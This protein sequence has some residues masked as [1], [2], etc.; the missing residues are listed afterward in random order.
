[1]TVLQFE[2]CQK[3]WSPFKF[4]FVQFESCCVNQFVKKKKRKRKKR[5]QNTV[6]Y[7][8]NHRQASV[9]TITSLICTSCG[10]LHQ[11]HSC[12]KWES[13]NG[14]CPS[15]PPVQVLF[16]AHK[17]VIIDDLLICSC[18]PTGHNDI[19]TQLAHLL[20]FFFFKRGDSHG[21]HLGAPLSDTEVWWTF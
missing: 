10:L 7:R 11:Y 12:C 16:W 15:W 5:D 4:I 3:L 13:V 6:L 9:I 1:M 17:Q 21:S 18:S 2:R 19:W 8:T 20:F 14:L